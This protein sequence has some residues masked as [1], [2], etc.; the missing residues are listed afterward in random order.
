M[1]EKTDTIIVS[2]T[3][4]TKRIQYC[5]HTVDLMRQQTLKPDKIV[6]NLSTDEFPRKEEELPKELVA[7]QD[8]VFEIYWV[9]ENNKVYKKIIP[10]LKRFPEDVIISIDDDI[11]YPKNFIEE[12]YGKFV[13]YGKKYPIAGYENEE[14][15]VYRHS[16]PFSLVKAEFFGDYL[17]D[18]YE[19]VVVVYGDDVIHASDDIYFYAA[20]LQG[21]P[22]RLHTGIAEAMKL[23]YRNSMRHGRFINNRYSVYDRKWRV[24]YNKQIEITRNYIHDRYKL[25][26]DDLILKIKK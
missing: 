13:E 11:E 12:M 8:D 23:L 16:G 20:L 24:K 22:Y 19:N 4:W 7:A 10:T 17:D 6:L 9:K 1:I 2:F 14:N 18:L 26:Y 5:K 25:T 21:V 15:G 3:S